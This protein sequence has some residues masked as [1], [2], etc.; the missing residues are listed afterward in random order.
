MDEIINSQKF[1]SSEFENLKITVEEIKQQD[2]LNKINH[3]NEEII[4]LEKQISEQDTL[5]DDLD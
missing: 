3:L 1:L 4:H 5:R 2:F